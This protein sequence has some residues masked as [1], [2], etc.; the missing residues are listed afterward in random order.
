MGRFEGGKGSL[1]VVFRFPQWTT[2]LK[3]QVAIV[4]M[5]V[6]DS[7]HKNPLSQSPIYLVTRQHSGRERNVDKQTSLGHQVLLLLHLCPCS[8]SALQQARHS[9]K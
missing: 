7:V 6:E 1:C 4:R 9:P 8:R 2:I 3:L 5:R